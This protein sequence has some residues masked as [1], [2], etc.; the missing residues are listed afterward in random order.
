MRLQVWASPVEENIVTLDGLDC[1]ARLNLIAT[2]PQER[3]SARVTSVSSELAF[4]DTAYSADRTSPAHP[5]L[6]EGGLGADP[7]VRNDRSDP[8]RREADRRYV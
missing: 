5:I 4:A 8:P 3:V 6:R 1:Y 7:D 2:V